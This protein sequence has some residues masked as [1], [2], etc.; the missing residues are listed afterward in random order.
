MEE[1]D[2]GLHPAVDGRCQGTSYS[3]LYLRGTVD[4]L[5]V[6]KLEAG[7]SDEVD[8]GDKKAPGVRSVYDQSL[9]QNPKR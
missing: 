9:Q 2:R 5:M 6:P 3:L 8:E 4:K 1:S 7:I